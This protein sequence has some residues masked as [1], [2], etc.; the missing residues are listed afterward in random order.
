MNTEK[1]N[2]KKVIII[3][4]GFSSLSA[5]C[6]LAKD[7]FDVTVIEKN[8]DLGGRARVLEAYLDHKSD[9]VEDML[10]LSEDSNQNKKEKKQQKKDLFRFD[11]GPSWY[12][13][14]EVFENFFNDF[15]KKV[16]DYYELKKLDPAYR[17]IIDKDKYVDFPAQIEDIFKLFNKLEGDNKGGLKLAHFLKDGEY[18]YNKAIN[19]YMARPSYNILEFANLEFGLGVLKGG[20]LQSYQYQINKQ[21]TN[22]L[23]REILN[24]PTL[25]LGATPKKTPYLYSLMAYTMIVHGTWYPM[26]GMNSIVQ[27]M[28]S[29]GKEL[30]VKY[31]INCNV[32]KIEIENNQAVAVTVQDLA[33]GQNKKLFQHNNSGNNNDKSDTEAIFDK[34]SIT[35][36][37]DLQT[38][39]VIA[40]SDYHHSETQLL[41]PKYRQYSDKY[42]D[43]RV[44]SPSSLIYYLGLDKTI[45][46]LSHH[47]LF[48]DADFDKHADNIYTNPQ[49]PQDPLFYACVPS[50]TDSSVAPK[51]HENMF[52]LLPIAP[53]LEDKEQIREE[54]FEKM[55]KRINQQVGFDIKDHIVYK[56]S[57]CINDFKMDYNSF[58]G[59]AYGLANTIKQTAIFKPSLRNK[60]VK[61]LFYCGQLTVPGPGVPPSL[62]SGRL[63]AQEIIKLHN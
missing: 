19:D 34:V 47:N 4:S 15:G 9:Q 51:G 14:P 37:Y 39:Y 17:L 21:F 33:R 28:V 12:W 56:K 50:K 61:N 13:M 20:L 43:K 58:K 18:T 3:G 46:N 32:K 38:D 52:L 57:Y 10:V 29:L 41:D 7:G 42:W 36:Y 63:A 35:D 24:Y 5:A 2:K 62:Y 6:Y 55:I 59:N 49:Y 11:M 44:L 1:S 45:P 26:G 31:C 54:Y 8:G 22:P 60:H 48:F 27:A 23:S 53:D 40:G 16:S 30:G 25:F